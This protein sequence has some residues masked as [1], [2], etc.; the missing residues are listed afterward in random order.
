M[1]TSPPNRSSTRVTLT[2][3]LVGEAWLSGC[4][5]TGKQTKDSNIDLDQTFCK[6]NTY[7]R[8]AYL[9]RDNQKKITPMH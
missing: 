2:P 6:K 9:M 1:L 5:P 7:N 8:S 4:F 3:Y